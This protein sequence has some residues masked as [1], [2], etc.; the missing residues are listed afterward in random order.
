MVSP[1]LPVPVPSRQLR[2][3]DAERESAVQALSEH[4]AAGRLRKDE[5]DERLAAAM[6]ARTYAE[7]DALFPDLPPLYGATPVPVSR[8]R[9]SSGAHRLAARRSAGLASRRP[10]APPA[11]FVV[12]ALL[13]IALEAPAVLLIPLIWFW[14]ARR[15][16]APRG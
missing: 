11:L 1:D 7:L 10:P 4:F 2:V 3:G 13:A 16:A 12:L 8:P 5:F 15:S 6:T 9:S 14:F